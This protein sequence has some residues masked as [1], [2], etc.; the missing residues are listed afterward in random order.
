MKDFHACPRSDQ[1]LKQ[2]NA[3]PGVMYVLESFYEIQ[4]P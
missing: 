1:C 2:M 3:E 4:R